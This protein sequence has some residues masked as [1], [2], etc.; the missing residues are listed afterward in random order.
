MRRKVAGGQRH[1]P[2]QQDHG[3]HCHRI[4]GADPVEQA[5][6]ESRQR[7]RESQPQP[8][9]DRGQSHSLQ[10]YQPQHSATRSAKGYTDGDLVPP[11][12]KPHQ[13]RRG[14]VGACQQQQS[15]YQREVSKGNVAEVTIEA[16]D[17]IPQGGLVTHVNDN[18]RRDFLKGLAVAGVAGMGLPLASAA[19][20]GAK[21]PL[22]KPVT[23]SLVDNQETRDGD[24]TET[25]SKFEM[26][27]SNDAVHRIDTLLSKIGG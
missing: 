9:P 16:E 8:Q 12:H 27:G 6:D 18:N 25:H 21:V 11:R 22:V 4:V 23:L 10:Q 3:K 24:R 13:G 5:G 14:H 26:T 20:T 7:K 15:S 19:E 1:C 2:Q 17:V